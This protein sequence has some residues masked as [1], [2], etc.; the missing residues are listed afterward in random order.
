MIDYQSITPLMSVTNLVGFEPIRLNN[1][2]VLNKINKLDFMSNAKRF[3]LIRTD[4][5]FI[6]KIN[7]STIIYG[8]N[9]YLTHNGSIHHFLT[10][11]GETLKHRNVPL[12]E[13]KQL[14]IKH[15]IQISTRRQ[16]LN[17]KASPMLECRLLPDGT[18]LVKYYIIMPYVKTNVENFGNFIDDI[19]SSYPTTI[20]DN[21]SLTWFH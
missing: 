6:S 9:Y 14:A 3:E 1:K 2:K 20:W 18:L 5:C 16:P 7:M 19:K 13:L 4:T 11:C 21:N 15:H 10:D 17:L 12:A 8:V